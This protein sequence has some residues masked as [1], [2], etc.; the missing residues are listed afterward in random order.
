MITSTHAKNFI[1]NYQVAEDF[2]VDETFPIAANETVTIK[3]LHRKERI[4]GLI[5][6]DT[7]SIESPYAQI[8]SVGEGVKG[9][10]VG[11]TVKYNQNACL[12]TYHKEEEYYN[13]SE[14]DIYTIRPEDKDK[15]LLHT[16]IIENVGVSNSSSKVYEFAE[17]FVPPLGFKVPENFD[18]PCNRFILAKKLD[19]SMAARKSG[20]FVGELTK[21]GVNEGTIYAVGP[22]VKSYLRPGMNIVWNHFANNTVDIDG[23]DYSIFYDNDVQTIQRDPND[24]M[25]MENHKIEGR[26]QYSVDEMPSN[27]ASKEELQQEEEFGRVGAEILKKD[28]TT[29]IHAVPGQKKD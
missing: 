22:N 3:K 7:T 5:L 12:I 17:S 25:M 16:T 29:K 13:L 4:S 20:I 1:D 21:S 15:L 26:K 9:L 24:T 18:V 14:L 8:Y 11:M 23:M 6:N 19:R 27:V 10:K 2:K 28:A